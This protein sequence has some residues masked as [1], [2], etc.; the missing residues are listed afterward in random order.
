MSSSSR[1]SAR[2]PGNRRLA[3][4]SSTPA[5]GHRSHV[6]QDG[7]S[8]RTP[9]MLAMLAML[10]C[11]SCAGERPASTP[12]RRDAPPLASARDGAKERDGASS[13]PLASPPLGLIPAPRTTSRCAGSFAIDGSTEI[14]VDAEPASR[15][16]GLRLAQWLGIGASL[17]R[18]IGAGEPGPA[19]AIVVRLAPSASPRRDPSV[20][21]PSD[22]NEEAYTLD[23]SPDRALLRASHPAGLFYGAQTLAQL[24]G[25]RPLLAPA[26]HA[27]AAPS[28]SP[29]P[30]ASKPIPC[31]RIDDA[32]S[33]RVRAMH[34]DVARHFFEKAIV[35]RYVDLLSFYRFNVFHLHLTDDQGFRLAIRSHPELT[36]VGARRIEDGNEH[37]GSYTQD[38]AREI[39]AFAK[40]RFVTV[41]PEIEMPGHARAILA[42]H[43]ELSCTGKKQA[44]PSTWGVFDDVLCAGNGG[45]FTL[46]ADVLRETTEVFPSELIHLGGDEVPKTRWRSCPKCRARMGNEKLN[47]EQLQGAFLRRA[48]AM[49]ASHGRRVMAWDEALDG[50]LPKGGVVVAWQNAERG[51]VGAVAGHDV[52][53]APSDTTYF[54]YWQTRAGTEPGHEGYLPWTK[55]LAFD[56]VP[57]GLDPTQAARILGGEGALWTEHV[58]TRDDLDTLL[59]PR[60]AALSEALWQAGERSEQGASAGDVASF[61]ARFAAQRPLLDASDVRYFVEPPT[62]LRRRMLFLGTTSIAL[63]PPSLHPDGVVRFTLDGSEPTATSPI[64]TAPLALSATTTVSARLFLPGGRTSAVVRGT[65][66]HATLRPPIQPS[67]LPEMLNEGVLYKYYEGDFHA[68][69]DFAKLTPKRTGRARSLG[70]EP[71]FRA[72]RFAVMYDAWFRAPADGIYRFVA[73]ADDGVWLE[74]DGVRVVTDDGEH[75]AREADGEIALAR[76]SHTVRVGYFQGTGGKEL[77]LTCGGPTLSLGR[78]SLVSP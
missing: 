74:I 45:T 51:R 77:S 3:V 54:N 37:A 11:N 52:V 68:L 62:G 46:L 20:H 56:P 32:P 17:V 31:L 47:A 66:E 58:K 1:A 30:F 71:S 49:L 70:F 23:V 29:S 63:A 75:A 27:G 76:G 21:V 73:T 69:P 41:V 39:V 43:P 14:V 44:V 6:C 40:D 34:L 10:A 59:L 65:L 28:P 42:A 57:R 18:T 16:V 36:R 55:V 2:S 78:C 15:A 26:P 12:P 25:S 38:E 8:L 13:A 19:H 4:D 53:M 5:L 61:V 7:P 60:L 9:A 22:T 33:Y 64:F 24:A 72:Q 50:G 48:S 67:M 35:E